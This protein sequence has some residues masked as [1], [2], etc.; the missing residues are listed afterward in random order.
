M[1]SGQEHAF[2]ESFETYSDALFRHALF[3]LSDRERALDITQEAF[4]K[5]WDYVVAGNEITQYKSFLYR[6]LNNLIID[7]YRKKR[8]VSLDEIL[9][10]DE[11]SATVE[12]KLSEGSLMQ[13][14][15]D[16]DDQVLAERIRARIPELPDGYRAVITLRFVEGL[17]NGEIAEALELS[18]NVVAVRL[19]RG[20]YKLRELCNV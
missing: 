14:E 8:S 6:I 10:D 2:Q 11:R 18:E 7:E 13:F 16:L 4:L 3:R 20:I 17:S 12:M 9:E 19:H 1:T 15:S 5:A